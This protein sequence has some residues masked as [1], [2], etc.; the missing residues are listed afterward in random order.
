MGHFAALE[1]LTDAQFN[2]YIADIK[3]PSN[4]FLFKAGEFFLYIDTVGTKTITPASTLEVPEGVDTLLIPISYD[5]SPKMK[6]L[7]R[8]EDHFALL[9]MK[10]N[11]EDGHW[12]AT[13]VDGKMLEGQRICKDPRYR[14]VRTNLMPKLRR[15]F[16]QSIPMTTFRFKTEM[17]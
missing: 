1:G 15:K 6:N 11:K 17:R 4:V 14:R 8:I 5:H 2:K 10:M 13:Y 9:I 7:R 12:E 16:G 3:L